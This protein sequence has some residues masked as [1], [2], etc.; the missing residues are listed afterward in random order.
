MDEGGRG[1]RRNLL[2]GS[3]RAQGQLSASRS[4]DSDPFT[5]YID[6]AIAEVA[7]EAS[8]FG[9]ETDDESLDGKN[10]HFPAYRNLKALYDRVSA[11]FEEQKAQFQ[12][13]VK[14]DFVHG[15]LASLGAGT[16]SPDPKN[17]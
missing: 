15:V 5:F 17:G 9:A 13:I 7:D 3:R 1:G 12:Q 11:P 2:L 4:S 8:T 10:R 16:S 6:M 14:D